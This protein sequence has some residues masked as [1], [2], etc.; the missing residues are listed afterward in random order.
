MHQTDLAGLL[1]DTLQILPPPFSRC[2]GVHTSSLRQHFTRTELALLQGTCALLSNIVAFRHATWRR[3]RTEM[4]VCVWTVP[5][6]MRGKARIS[7]QRFLQ[8]CACIFVQVSRPAAKSAPKRSIIGKDELMT[9]A[10]LAFASLLLDSQIG[11]NLEASVQEAKLV[12][13][14]AEP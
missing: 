11:A 12:D 3:C 13:H 4:K 9:G 2:L 7:R 8:L 5:T 6:R 14:L 1:L 10:S